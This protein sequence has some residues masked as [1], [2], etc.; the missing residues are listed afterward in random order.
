MF[1]YYFALLAMFR[2]FHVVP[3][4]SSFRRSAIPLFRVLVTSAKMAQSFFYHSV[5]L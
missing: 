3:Y 5:S 4:I 2:V 1:Y